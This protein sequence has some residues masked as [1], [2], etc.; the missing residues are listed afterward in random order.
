M[1]YFKISLLALI[2]MILSG[3]SVNYE[4]DITNSKFSE[5]ANIFVDS[6]SPGAMSDLE[7]GLNSK[8]FPITN[9]FDI[10]YITKD[11]T[12]ANKPGMNASYTYTIDSINNN[13]ITKNCFEEFSVT[14]DSM[15]IAIRAKKF[16]CNE[17]NYRK[18][19]NINVSITTNHVVYSANVKKVKGTYN[20]DY[21][22]INDIE[23]IIYK[24]RFE[25][26]KSQRMIKN[27]LLVAL[28]GGLTTAFI[29]FKKN[30]KA[31]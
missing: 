22:S 6:N 23:L 7:M 19:E 27:I 26:P 18:I 17:Y 4:L 15:F 31:F 8:Q 20:W 2:A 14:E 25:A 16:L 1:K 10:T 13:L 30:K 9:N 28:F 21:N 29:L 12:T 3:C 5:S 24:D 11:I